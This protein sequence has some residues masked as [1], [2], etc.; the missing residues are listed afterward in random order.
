MSKILYSLLNEAF[1]Y[2]KRQ[3]ECIVFGPVISS[4]GIE[5]NDVFEKYTKMIM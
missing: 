5:P 2:K 3:G 1:H 4:L